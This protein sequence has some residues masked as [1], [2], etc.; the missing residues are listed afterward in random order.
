MPESRVILAKPVPVSKKDELAKRIYYVDEAILGYSLVIVGNLVTEVVFL[1]G[2]A[3][4]TAGISRKMD[5]M[6]DDEIRQL[7]E[8]YSTRNLEITA[9]S[10]GRYAYIRPIGGDRSAVRKWR[11]T[12][13]NI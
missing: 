10:S 5:A 9:P 6:I 8:L 13:R 7:S 1:V 11:R 3:T 12:V 2:D 4:L